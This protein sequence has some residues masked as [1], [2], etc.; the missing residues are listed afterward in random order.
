MCEDHKVCTYAFLL[1]AFVLTFA[2]S[3]GVTQL[4]ASPPAKLWEGCQGDE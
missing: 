1:R 2:A 3:G 4:C